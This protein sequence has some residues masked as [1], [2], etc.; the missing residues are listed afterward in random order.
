MDFL[1]PYQYQ[2]LNNF[3]KRAVFPIALTLTGFVIVSC[4]VLYSFIKADLEKDTIKH[5]ANLAD[6]IIKSTRYSMLKSDRETLFMTIIAIGSQEDVEHVRIFN[7]KGVIKFS[8]S[9]DELNRQVDKKTAGCIGCHS[10]SEPE[11]RLRSME[12]ARRYVNEHGNEV[13]AITA[14]IYGEETCYSGSCHVH[15]PDQYVLG[16]LD[17]GLSQETFIQSLASLRLRMIVFCVMILVLSVGG[18]A[19]L[20]RRNVLVPINDLFDYTASLSRGE[21]DA[22]VPEGVSEIEDLAKT[23]HGMVTDQRKPGA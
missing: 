16:T 12:S 11:T 8:S 19:A 10:V 9:S 22:P 7:K 23:I 21:Y 4:M 20:L 18:G 1:Q 13:L 2:M 14:P 17:I 6:T 3:L 5:E 15:S